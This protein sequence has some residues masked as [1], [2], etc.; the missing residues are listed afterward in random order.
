MK[1]KSIIHA[2][3]IF[4]L[5][6]LLLLPQIAAAKHKRH[7]SSSRT[8][9]A[10]STAPKVV[11]KSLNNNPELAQR[12]A[13]II[14]KYDPTVN[15]GIYVTSLQDGA[16]LYQQNATR[17]YSPAS[18]LKTFTAAA[19]LLYLGPEYQFNTQVVSLTNQID[20]NGTLNGD[21]YFY[22]DGDPTLTR[23]N[24]AALVASLAQAG[25]R[26]IHGN[27]YIDDSIFD[28]DGYGPGW[29][30]DEEIACYAAPTHA[31]MLDRNCFP[32]QLAASKHENQ[33]ATFNTPNEA[34]PVVNTVMTKRL[35]YD[36]CP[37]DLKATDSNMYYLSGCV[38]P[39]SPEI[40]WLVAVK[41]IRIYAEKVLE[42]LIADKQIKLLGKVKFAKSPITSKPDAVS[43]KDYFVLANHTSAPLNELVKVM[44]K[45]SDNLIADALFKKIGFLYFHRTA[46]WRNSSKALSNILAQNAHIDFR[47]TR[48]LDGSGLSQYNLVT[49]MKMGQLLNFVYH[50]ADIYPSFFAA[51]PI[52]G[53]DGHLQSRMSTTDLRG[54]VHAKTGTMK[55]VTS[56][57]GFLTTANAK[58]VSFAIIINGFVDSYHKYRL[59]EDEICALFARSTF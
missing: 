12:I 28:Q 17:L 31:V 29:S 25:I 52:S 26:T 15:V 8:V 59:I 48:I 43:G 56:L 22:F 3:A 47:N 10:A 55:S 20:S 27:V 19:A 33:P 2:V 44:L 54:K 18:S 13:A 6:V 11:L 41:N 42:N 57:A 24:L 53:V 50:N 34:I 1:H 23:Q 16:V 36:Q 14:A 30:S 21:L 49:P 9:S 45:K 58:P 37:L 51:L 39:N 38:W 4:L 46:T 7:S 32:L 40:S 5:S 35:P